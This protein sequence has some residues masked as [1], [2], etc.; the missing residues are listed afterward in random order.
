MLMRIIYHNHNISTLCSTCILCE[1][2]SVWV[3]AWLVFCTKGCSEMSGND[4]AKNMQ[5][6]S[7]SHVIPIKSHLLWPYWGHTPFSDTQLKI[8]PFDV[9]RSLLVA[10]FPRPASARLFGEMERFTVPEVHRAALE[11]SLLQVMALGIPIHRWG[12]RLEW[13]VGHL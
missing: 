2:S 12:I 10:V 1:G 7:L 8:F 13:M 9:P 5:L 11:G 4:F 6:P 3:G